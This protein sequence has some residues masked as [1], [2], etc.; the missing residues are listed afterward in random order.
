MAFLSALKGRQRWAPHI[1][2]VATLA[3]E[4]VKAGGEYGDEQKKTGI[5]IHGLMGAGKNLRT[6]AKDLIS[7]VNQS[8]TSSSKGWELVLIDLRNHGNSA[9]LSHLSPP[10]NIQ[11]AATDI[12]ELVKLELHK[13]PDV[14]IGHSL[15][16]KVALEFAESC[17]NGRFG[18]S[19]IY[20][21]QVWV[22]DSVPGRIDIEQSG[23]VENVLK[24]IKYLPDPLP[25]RRWLVEHLVSKGFSK[26]LADWLGTNLKRISASSEEMTWIFDVDGIYD[27]YLSYRQTN[28]W[29][30]LESPPKGMDIGIVRAERSDRW[31]PALLSKLEHLAN[32]RKIPHSDKG[33]VSYHV[34]EKAGHWLHVDN[35]KGLIE[36]LA[37]SLIKMSQ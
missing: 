29:P 19:A 16:G 4:Y 12:A 25:S 23:E 5:I 2:G 33:T 28:Y 35:P 15:G 22:L 3:H 7:T 9:G 31:Y 36:I 20:P 30:F 8:C 34:L 14:I 17:V 13:W 26:P 1:R 37:P 10:H 32:T 27:M 21:T 11:A 24:T 18:H 6:L